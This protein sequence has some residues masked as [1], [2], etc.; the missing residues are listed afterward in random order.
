MTNG[1]IQ[2]PKQDPDTM[3]STV[4]TNQTGNNGK[5]WECHHGMRIPDGKKQKQNKKRQKKVKKTKKQLF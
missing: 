3:T 4:L 2:T 5:I 1:E